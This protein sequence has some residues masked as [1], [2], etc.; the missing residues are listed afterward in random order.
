MKCGLRFVGE[1]PAE[2]PPARRYID[3]DVDVMVLEPPPES[4]LERWLRDQTYYTAHGDQ[5]SSYRRTDDL[6]PHSVA[7]PILDNCKHCG[8]PI[9]WEQ[10]R[11]A[12]LTN[13]VGPMIACPT[14]DTH[15]E[16]EGDGPW[17]S[18]ADV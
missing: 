8:R 1:E 16:A 15:A 18:E 7:R 3:G 9:M 17:M 14:G 11:W 5:T 12:H 13:A 4:R 6:P 2:K 10:Q